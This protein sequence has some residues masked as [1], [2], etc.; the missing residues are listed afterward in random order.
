LRQYG[1][2][3][4][5]AH[6]P[7]LALHTDESI[8]TD[9]LSQPSILGIEAKTYRERMYS[10]TPLPAARASDE[11][12]GIRFVN[13]H[14][15]WERTRGS[16]ARVAVIDTGADYDHSEI[17]QRFTNLRGANFVSGGE[18]YDDNGHGTHVCG[19]IAGN[20]VGVAP[21]ATLYAI[22]VLNSEGYGTETAVLQGIE[23]AI[24]NR[25]NVINLSLGSSVPSTAERDLVAL[26]ARNEIN[27]ACA[28]GNDGGFVDNYPAS[29]DGATSVA[30]INNG[31]RRAPF[32]N[33]SDH[34]ALAAPGVA[35]Y[36]CVPGDRY[37]TLSGTSMA[38]P[39]VAGAF[40]LLASVGSD[41]REAILRKTAHSI[42]P[43]NEYGAGLIDCAEAL[44]RTTV[45]STTT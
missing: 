3:T 13:A 30:A 35:V 32:S 4:R 40:A 18:P 34:L 31:K 5:F 8:I 17:E 22:K 1:T 10:V 37:D 7:Y 26:A 41:E 36:S 6:I 12:W 11:V 25:V 27:L 29:Y 39:H 16:G 38:A 19:T 33:C 43:S 45:R 44:A 2:V 42:G 28:A 24:D 20:R 15:A 23:W 9:I 21:E 14:K